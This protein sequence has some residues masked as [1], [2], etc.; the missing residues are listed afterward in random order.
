MINVGFGASEVTTAPPEGA[1]PHPAP[2]NMLETL[3]K[4]MASEHDTLKLR[5]QKC[6]HQDEWTR[7]KALETF[8][9]DASPSLVRHRLVCGA[10]YA[11]G[12]SEV[13]I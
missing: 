4:V 1:A 5:C 7:A 12:H 10:C 8:G 11:R 6:G 3:Q 9:A 2:P 13:W